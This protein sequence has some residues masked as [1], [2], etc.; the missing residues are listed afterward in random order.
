MT[1]PIFSDFTGNSVWFRITPYLVLLALENLVN[2]S[3]CLSQGEINK[4]LE[5]GKEY[6]TKGQWGD[7]LT[8]YHA[9][10]DGDPTNYLTYFKRG[11]VYL[12][13]GKAK[14]ALG[15][16]DK[17]LEL[18]P[19]FTAARI[20]RGNIH[21]KQGSYDLAQL[22]L[23]NVL[24]VDPDNVEANE[25][26]KR[27]EPAKERKRN[28]EYYYGYNDYASAIQYL[29][30]AIEVSPWAASF[31]EF[32]AEMHLETGNEIAAISDIKAATKLQSDN[33]DGFLKLAQILYKTGSATESLKAIRECLKL[34]P[35]H[36]KCFAFYKQIKKVEKVLVEAETAVENNNYAEGK[37]KRFK[38]YN[39]IKKLISM[40]FL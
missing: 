11:T 29:N 39:R 6:L 10:V 28:A 21:L 5:Q 20:G 37:Y 27:I 14:N 32:R 23:Y 19:D 1:S 22:D 36:K 30:E 9:A 18:K 34:D 7:A 17:V 12:A 35:D 2:V 24:K 31:Y 33:T 13:L 4:H 38:K 15:D 8:H 26:L 16:F 25:L 40:S 3:E